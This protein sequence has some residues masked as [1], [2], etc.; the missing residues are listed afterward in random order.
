MAPTPNL[1]FGA[2]P[3]N[4]SGHAVV[5]D[6]SD[7]LAQARLRRQAA[8]GPG[9]QRAASRGGGGGAPPR[10]T[11]QRGLGVAALERLRCGGEAPPRKT[12]HRGLSMAELERLCCG[13]VDPLHDLNTAANLQAQ[14]NSV[15]VQQT[16][17]CLADRGTRAPAAA[18]ATN[19]SYYSIQYA[20]AAITMTAV[21]KVR[22]LVRGVCKA[23][24][25]SS[26]FGRTN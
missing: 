15:I 3:E 5:P 9:R 1:L 17:M 6:L 22:A 24:H 11:P 23:R 20:A 19:A 10:T 26:R 8:S 16:M 18:N 21:R 13:V 12:L 14:G 4:T 2:G 25:H 7:A